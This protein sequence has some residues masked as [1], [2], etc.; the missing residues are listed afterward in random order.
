[1][2]CQRICQP[3]GGRELLVLGEES[4]VEEAADHSTKYRRNPEHP[5]LTECPALHEKCGSRTAGGVDRSIRDG[6]ADQVDKVRHSPIAIGARPF[7][8]RLSVEPMMTSRKKQV[9]QPQ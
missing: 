4:V 3:I 8:A 6:N 5:E 1:M 9:T 7:G 2:G